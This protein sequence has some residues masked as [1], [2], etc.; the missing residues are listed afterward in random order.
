[1]YF[2]R[3]LFLLSAVI[4]TVSAL[5]QTGGNN[6]Y[7]FLNLPISARVS[8]LG[9]NLIPVKDNDLNVSLINPS[10]LSDSMS[11]NVAL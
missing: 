3:I 4:L 6:T 11:N 2:R 8:A 9:G 5:A 1:M 7:E 10:L